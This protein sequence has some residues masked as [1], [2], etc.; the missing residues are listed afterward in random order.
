M[1]AGVVVLSPFVDLAVSTPSFILNRPFDYITGLTG[2]ETTLRDPKWLGANR[3]HYYC[4]N[5]ELK[6]HYVSPI[7]ADYFSNPSSSLT[8]TIMPPSQNDDLY[9]QQVSNTTAT[10][11]APALPP[12]LIQVGG[13][14]ML[15]DESIIL[16]NSTLS[17]HTDIQLEIYLDQPHVVHVFHNIHPIAKQAFR[18]MG[19]FVR[20]VVR[21]RSSTSSSSSSGP[22]AVRTVAATSSMMSNIKRRMAF[23]ISPTGERVL[24]EEP[25]QIVE[26]A[27]RLLE[28]LK[29]T[30]RLDH[31]EKIL[32]VFD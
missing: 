13:M 11:S 9:I 22:A 10:T 3:T 6:N 4:K 19:E 25:M 2:D 28:E 18:N 5:N 26:Q 31:I 27:S 20:R 7:L 1:P 14:E 17:K 15:R 23:E 32:P 30:G 16:F 21:E 29:S 8:P 12:I 24:V